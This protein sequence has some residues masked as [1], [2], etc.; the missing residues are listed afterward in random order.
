MKINKNSVPEEQ[1][2]FVSQKDKPVPGPSLPTFDLEANHIALLERK[3]LIDIYKSILK[4]IK[5]VYT[6][7]KKHLRG[8]VIL[9][10]SEALQR[11]KTEWSKNVWN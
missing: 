7:L 1:P 6:E 10:E 5:P 11:K 2:S 8:E 4:N 3:D 9:T